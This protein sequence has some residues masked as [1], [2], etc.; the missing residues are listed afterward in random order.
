MRKVKRYQKLP[1]NSSRHW[2][3]AVDTRAGPGAKN[4]VLPR[5]SENISNEDS[6]GEASRELSRASDEAK[7]RFSLVETRER[8]FDLL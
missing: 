7:A 5:F 2:A 6:S 3:H 8:H 1:I 4:F